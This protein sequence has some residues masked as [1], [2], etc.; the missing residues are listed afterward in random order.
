MIGFVRKSRALYHAITLVL[1]PKSHSLC[2]QVMIGKIT[3]N[4]SS[5]NTNSNAIRLRIFSFKSQ[6]GLRTPF[7]HF[8]NPF[9]KPIL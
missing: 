2:V 1:F 8:I 5:L 3:R 9:K 7:S 4:V 6:I